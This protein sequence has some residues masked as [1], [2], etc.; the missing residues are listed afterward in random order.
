MQCFFHLRRGHEF[1]PDMRG[2]ALSDLGLARTEAMNAIRE[3]LAHEGEESA[4]WVGWTLEV[5]D[6]LGE[7]LFVLP[8]EHDAD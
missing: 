3:T 8:L 5:A 4:L 7:V 1:L 6:P 2:V